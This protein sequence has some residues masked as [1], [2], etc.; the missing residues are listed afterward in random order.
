M[1][2]SLKTILIMDI[3]LILI[4]KFLN[5]FFN[6]YILI[7][8]INQRFVVTFLILMLIIISLIYFNNSNHKKLKQ[9]YKFISC[10]FIIPILLFWMIPMNEDCY[11]YFKSPDNSKTLVAEE[12]SFLLFGRS[13]F[14]EKKYH[15]LIKSLPYCIDIDDGI[16]IFSLNEYKIK[17]ID[18]NTVYL[19]Y[20]SGCGLYSDITIKLP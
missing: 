16:R 18:N 14:Y 8:K 3:F 17:W 12:H 1:K 4:I 11:F 20:D 19:E 6:L 9:V 7:G 10:V 5:I 2:N 15:I 13:Y